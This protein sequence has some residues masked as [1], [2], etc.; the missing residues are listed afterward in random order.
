MKDIPF[1]NLILKGII[2]AGGFYEIK[3]DTDSLIMTGNK[4]TIGVFL[5][6]HYYGGENGCVRAEHIENF[7]KWKQ[8]FYTSPLP[9]NKKQAHAILA[10]LCY[11]NTPIN[12]DLGRSFGT[13][14]RGFKKG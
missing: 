8:C 13:L 12:K 3:L 14:T 1:L 7:N 10:D 11:I 2:Q 4:L 5:S 6:D 9:Q